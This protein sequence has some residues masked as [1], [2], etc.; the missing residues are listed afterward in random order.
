MSMVTKAAKISIVPRPGEVMAC[1]VCGY[2][3]G[4]SRQGWMYSHHE[5]RVRPDRRSPLRRVVVYVA[6]DRCRGA[7]DI[8]LPLPLHRNWY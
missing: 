2:T 4:V 5:R 3:E 6:K 1:P 8:A 7:G